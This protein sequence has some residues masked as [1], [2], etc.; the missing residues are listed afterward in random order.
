MRHGIELSSVLTEPRGISQA[1]EKIHAP[2]PLS[3]RERWNKLSKGAQIAIAASVIGVTALL[4][5]LYA[6]CC[7][8]QRRA[9]KRERRLADSAWEKEQA[10]LNEYRRLMHEQ[11][12]GKGP[13]VG[14][15]EIGSY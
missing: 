5:V 12:F 11:H 10:E 3:P 2:P 7:I 13:S 6:F 14:V 4:I 9:G 8:K 1:N 15:R